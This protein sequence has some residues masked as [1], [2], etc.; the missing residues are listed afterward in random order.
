M[1]KHRLSELRIILRSRFIYCC[2]CKCVARCFYLL[3]A[4]LN[5]VAV[6]DSVSIKSV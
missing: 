2:N 3:E 6:T 1:L 5:Y 4:L